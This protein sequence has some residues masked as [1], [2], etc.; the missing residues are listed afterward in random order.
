MAFSAVGDADRSGGYAPGI[1]LIVKGPVDRS[2]SASKTGSGRN[3]RGSAVRMRDDRDAE[4]SL[5]AAMVDHSGRRRLW[6]LRRASDRSPACVPAFLTLAERCALVDKDSS[7]G[8]TAF[9]PPLASTVRIGFH[10]PFVAQWSSRWVKVANGP[11][12]CG[13]SRHRAHEW[14]MYT[15]PLMMRRWLSR[16]GPCR[17]AGRCGAI[18]RHC[19][20]LYKSRP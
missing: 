20:S 11:Y 10:R 19:A 1:G 17:F 3:I 12:S 18:R 6:R 5:V 16:A 9:M 2:V 4:Q 8:V 15:P 7:D 13:Q 14:S